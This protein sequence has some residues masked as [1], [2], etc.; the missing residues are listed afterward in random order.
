[1]SAGLTHEGAVAVSYFPTWMEELARTFISTE[2]MSTRGGGWSYLVH[3]TNALQAPGEFRDPID[4]TVLTG[5]R[6]FATLEEAKAWVEQ[7]VAN[8]RKAS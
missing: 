5:L 3:R 7:D 8:R 2:C 4:G 6:S 1:M